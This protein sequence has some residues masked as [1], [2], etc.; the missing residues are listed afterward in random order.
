MGS[1][2]RLEELREPLIWQPHLGDLRAGAGF[3]CLLYGPL[4]ITFSPV[5]GDGYRVYVTKDA[6]KTPLRRPPPAR[7]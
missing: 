4:P 6:I 3:Y 2:D 1:L 7:R 5:N